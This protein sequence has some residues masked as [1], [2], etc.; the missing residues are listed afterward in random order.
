VTEAFLVSTGAVALAEMGDKTQLLALLLAARYRAP[1]AI[2]F[3]IALATLLNHAI[4]ASFGAW[5]AAQLGEQALRWILAGSFLAMA[6]WML[7]PDGASDFEGSKRLGVFGTTVLAFFL[8]EIGDKTQIATVALAAH[9]HA[10]VPVVLGTTAG[11]LVANVP[12]VYAGEAL[13]KR[14]PMKPLRYLAAAIFAGLAVW[15]LLA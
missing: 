8:V 2:T 3:G 13:M 15:T 12:V 10:F 7:F 14:L 9:Y 5:V 4:A 1:L 6:V 11:M